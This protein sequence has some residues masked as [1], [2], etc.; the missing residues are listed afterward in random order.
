MPKRAARCLRF[1]SS[2]STTLGGE[3]AGMVEGGAGGGYNRDLWVATKEA[4]NGEQ[5]GLGGSSGTTG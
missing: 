4:R 1:S 2:E 3:G 5:T